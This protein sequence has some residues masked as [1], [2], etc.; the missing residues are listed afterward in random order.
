MFRSIYFLL[1]VLTISL[2]DGDLYASATHSLSEYQN[3]K[4]IDQLQLLIQK[5][6]VIMH[7]VART[8][9]NQKLPIEDKARE[10]QSL[11]TINIKAKELGLDE[12]WVEAFFQAQFD[13]AKEIQRNDFALWENEGM[14]EFPAVLNLKTEIRV[15]LDEINQEMLQ[16][17]SQMPLEGRSVLD[18]P[19][20]QRLSDSVDISVWQMAVRPLKS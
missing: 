1:T 7:E 20:S 16:L 4:K 13:A 2:S 11:A 6:L 15:Y 3:E 9:W 5:R 14:G 17:L 8:K 10:L 19:I 18:K 12:K